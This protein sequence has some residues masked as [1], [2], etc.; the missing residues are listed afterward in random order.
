MVQ[1]GA[2][3]GLAFP[4]GV[5]NSGG[6]RPL[7]NWELEWRR[8]RRARH[9]GISKGFQRGI[10]SRCEKRLAANW[11]LISRPSDHASIT[12]SKDDREAK[13]R[14]IARLDHGAPHH[15][16]FE[17]GAVGCAQDRFQG[18]ASFARIDIRFSGHEQIH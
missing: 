3:P 17:G 8:A 11:E 5:V 16:V 13:K 14:N 18:S 1:P 12:S 15:V 2:T 9:R 4:R 10:E 7:R 6:E